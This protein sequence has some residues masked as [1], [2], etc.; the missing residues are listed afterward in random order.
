MLHCRS[1]ALTLLLLPVCLR[2]DSA[3]GT[4]SVSATIVAVCEVGVRQQAEV[5]V[6]CPQLHPYRVS[7]APA[8]EAKGRVQTGGSVENFTGTRQFSL[9]RFVADG[10]TSAQQPVANTSTTPTVTM[11]TISY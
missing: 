6:D 5:S 9:S 1:V 11:V 2:A 7:L 3:L 8:A 4:L 10:G